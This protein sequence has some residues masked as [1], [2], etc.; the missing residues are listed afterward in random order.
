VFVGSGFILS[1]MLGLL[2]DL[3]KTLFR[4][5]VLYLNVLNESPYVRQEK[6]SML[7]G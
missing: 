1:G 3:G 7:V 2:S 5:T 4:I 6:R